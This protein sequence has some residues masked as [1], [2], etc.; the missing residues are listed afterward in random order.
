MTVICRSGDATARIWDLC[1]GGSID[2]PLV[3]KHV[4][5]QAPGNKS[6]DVTTMDWSL[7]GN[8]LAT[9]SYDGLARIWT[10]EGNSYNSPCIEA[11]DCS[12]KAGNITC[13]VLV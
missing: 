11:P 7:D 4:N 12:A 1:D 3:L 6:K 10:K 5:M 2:K 8:F 9:G 13:P